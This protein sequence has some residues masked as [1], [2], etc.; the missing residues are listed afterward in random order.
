MV[1]LAQHGCNRRVP[2]SPQSRGEARSRK[3]PAES[4]AHGHALVFKRGHQRSQPGFAGSGIGIREDENLGPGVHRPDPVQQVVHLLTP[5]ARLPG[6]DEHRLRRAARRLLQALGQVAVGRVSLRSDDE[7]QLV[8]R[9][10]LGE[11][12][13]H[14]E[15]KAGIQPLA[16]DNDGR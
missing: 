2:G 14:V 10:V 9:V 11:E 7:N 4:C 16:R 5:S 12:S 6:G 3:I 15:L 8:R 1:V 13:C